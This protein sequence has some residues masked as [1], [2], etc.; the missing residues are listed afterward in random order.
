MKNYNRFHSHGYW[1]GYQCLVE[2]LLPG[3]TAGGAAPKPPPKDEK[4]E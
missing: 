3:G 4:G 2:A 1:N